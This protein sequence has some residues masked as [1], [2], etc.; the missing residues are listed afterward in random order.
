MPK[1]K[2]DLPSKN[3]KKISKILEDNFTNVNSAE[4]AMQLF[5]RRLSLVGQ[6][7]R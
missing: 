1:N 2:A 3:H 7:N 6:R 4:L 5:G